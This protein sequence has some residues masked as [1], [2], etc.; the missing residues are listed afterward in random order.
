MLQQ[1]KNMYTGTSLISN[2]NLYLSSNEQLWNAL[3]F[4][5]FDETEPDFSENPLR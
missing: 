2:T 1:I 3:L 5:L 4:R